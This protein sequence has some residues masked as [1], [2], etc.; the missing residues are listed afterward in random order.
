VSEL[1]KL[2]FD[3]MTAAEFEQYLPELFASG[4]GGRLSED[5]RL[6]KFLRANPDCAALVRDLETIAETAKGL[7]AAEEEPS[8]EVWSNIE[9]KLKH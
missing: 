9:K 6:T 5:P 1:S 2:D 3:A 4:E 7:F 8:D